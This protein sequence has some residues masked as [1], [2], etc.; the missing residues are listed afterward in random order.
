MPLP[1]LR[2]ES[3]VAKETSVLLVD[4][5]Y[6]SRTSGRKLAGALGAADLKNAKVLLNYDDGTFSLHTG[7]WLLA[8]RIPRKENWRIFARFRSWK[9]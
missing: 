7:P 6:F 3:F 2:A 1:E 9:R 5:D 8:R 4:M